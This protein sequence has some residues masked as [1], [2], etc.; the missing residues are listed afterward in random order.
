[1]LSITP[2]PARVSRG[3]H[4]AGGLDK[5]CLFSWAAGLCRNALI[6]AGTKAASVRCCTA[7]LSL[8][9]LPAVCAVRSAHT[10]SVFAKH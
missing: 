9:R 4:G 10:P 3:E 6:A 2:P 7:G 5:G 8:P 1:M